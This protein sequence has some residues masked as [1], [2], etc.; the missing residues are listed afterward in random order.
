MANIVSIEV[1]LGD[2]QAKSILAAGSY[3]ASQAL[4]NFINYDARGIM[5][6][7]N[8]TKLPGSGSTTWATKLKAVD[9]TVDGTWAT[10]KSGTAITVAAAGP[11]SA[12]GI[13][14]L[15]VY[16]GVSE[17]AGAMT[18]INSVLPRNFGIV[19][20]LSAGAANAGSSVLGI[21]YQFL[22]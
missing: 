2:T 20:S 17:T 15:I 4:G 8:I 13:T 6:F 19:A 16:P 11:K 12:S 22:K 3:S 21:S 7:T 5:I 18:R 1:P 10:G 14:V 9:P